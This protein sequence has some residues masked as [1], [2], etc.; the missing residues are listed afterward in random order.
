MRDFAD[1]LQAMLTIIAAT[2]TIVNMMLTIFLAV[3][4]KLYSKL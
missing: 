1:D 4:S 3:R 2:L